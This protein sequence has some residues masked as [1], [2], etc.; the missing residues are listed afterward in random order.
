MASCSQALDCKTECG[1]SPVCD[2][3][4]SVYF[5]DTL[6][7]KIFWYDSVSGAHKKLDLPQK[8]GCIVPRSRGGLLAALES[9]IVQVETE[10]LMSEMWKATEEISAIPD[11]QGGPQFRFND[12]KVDPAGRFWVGSMNGS[13]WPDPTAKKGSLYVLEPGQSQ[14]I[15]KVPST[16]VSNG[17]AWSSDRSKFFYVD[18][19][20]YTVDCFDYEE[21]TGH[22]N[23]RRTVVQ[24][25]ECEEI[26]KTGKEEEKGLPDGMAIDSNDKLWVAIGESGTVRQVDPETGKE[27]FRLTIP[28][29]RPTSCAFGGKDLSELYVTTKLE[30]GTGKGGGLYKCHIPGVKGFSFAHAYAG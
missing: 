29:A 27:L 25:P 6:G 20:L 19:T 21:A 23:N 30:E 18:S 11:G 9:P 15:E 10:V 4:G 2:A 8:A 3:S 26:E 13:D 22:I 24:F 28:A 17:L 16:T 5:V 7:Q 12:G 14:L 1:E